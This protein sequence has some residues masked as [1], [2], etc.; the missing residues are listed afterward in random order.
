MSAGHAEGPGGVG[1][2]LPGN[3]GQGKT[4]SEHT[5][6]GQQ[7]DQPQG[8]ANG[9]LHIQAILN[10]KDKQGAQYFRIIRPEL[11]ELRWS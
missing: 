11:L 8:Q 5:G 9:T 1:G 2:V 4:K 6:N 7:G 3:F 10:G